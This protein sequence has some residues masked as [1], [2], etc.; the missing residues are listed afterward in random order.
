M[1]LAVGEDV[2]R[3]GGGQRFARGVTA[4]A[5]AEPRHEDGASV[6]GIRSIDQL[7]LWCTL[8]TQV[9]IVGRTGSGKST[10]LMALFRMLGLAGGRIQVA[11]VDIA[12]L[13][14]QEV[15]RSIAIIPQVSM[16]PQVGSPV[17]GA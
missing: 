4:H 13:P 11:G 12:T 16:C 3:R 5:D 9:G 2:Q 1:A 14:L 17:A 15:R 8:V 10:L 6:P 7:A